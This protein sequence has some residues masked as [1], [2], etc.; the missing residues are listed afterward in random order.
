ML[1]TDGRKFPDVKGKGNKNPILLP[2]PFVPG[3]YT[4]R[5]IVALGSDSATQKKMLSCEQFNGGQ[6][7][8]VETV[9]DAK[10]RRRS[11]SYG[12]FGSLDR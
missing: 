6:G 8:H 7:Q 2:Y 12:S 10:K 5:C 9:L 11:E 4:R 3:F 1:Y